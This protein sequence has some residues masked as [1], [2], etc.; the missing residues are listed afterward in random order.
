MPATSNHTNKSLFAPHSY[1]PGQAIGLLGCPG[2]QHLLS[3]L[4]MNTHHWSRSRRRS[5]SSSRGHGLG[6]D[7]SS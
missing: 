2:R 4:F 6:F 7:R 1:Q 3:W 5:R